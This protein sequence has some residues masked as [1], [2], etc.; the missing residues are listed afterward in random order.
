MLKIILIIFLSI[1]IY[2]CSPINKQHGYLLDDVVLT[3]DKMS[4]FQDNVTKKEEILEIMGTPSIEIQDVDN[5]WIYLVSVKEKK[6]FDEDILLSQLIYR[7]AFNSKGVL[8]SSKTLT[9]EDF[10]DIS[11]SNEK[12]SVDRNAYSITDQL[13]DAFTR[14]Q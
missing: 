1:L 11:F 14:G 9:H 5:I 13:Y 4:K 7:F 2:S 3:S 12:T 6:V 10:E 8:I